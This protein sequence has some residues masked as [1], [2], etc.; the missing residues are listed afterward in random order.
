MFVEAETTRAVNYY[1]KCQ[2]RYRAK[3]N[4]QK[5]NLGHDGRFLHGL[6]AESKVCTH[7]FIHTFKMY[8]YNSSLTCLLRIH[9]I[10]C[11]F[12]VFCFFYRSTVSIKIFIFMRGVC[13]LSI[14]RNKG[15]LK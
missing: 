9:S 11:Y 12:W 3:G 13:S 7:T 8:K 6:T 4:D 10:F 15:V 14:H 5:Q 1:C 2:Q